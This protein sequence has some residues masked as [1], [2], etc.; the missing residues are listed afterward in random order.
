[1]KKGI[2]RD[3]T[4]TSWKHTLLL[5]LSVI[6]MTI[7]IIWRAFFTLPFGYGTVALVVGILLL[8][9]EALAAIE[10]F[11]EYYQINR[12]VIP[13]FPEID[14]SMYPDVDI[15]IATHNE[16]VELLYKTVNACTFLD[17][18]DRSKVHIYLCDDNNRPEMAELA[19]SLSV[20]YFGLEENKHAKAGNLNNA[21]KQTHSPLVAT[22]DSDMIVRSSFLM[23]TV[24]YFFLP[25]MKKND[26]G[27]WV[28]REE[29]EIDETYKIGF[30]QTPQSFYN[31]D[32]FQYNLYSE[33]RIP[34][35][36]DY[37][38]RDVNVGRNTSNAPIY[39]GSNTLLSREALEAAGYIAVNSIT[40]DF[41]TGMRIQKKG[42]CCFAIP[43]SVANG[44]APDSVK[45]LL[46]QRERW[47]RG[48]VQSCRNE[49]VI[50]TP[51]LTIAQK[52]SYLATKLYWWTFSRRAVYIL[53]PVLSVLFNLRIVIAPLWQVL[54]FWLPS[55]LL[56]N[57]TLR[58]L[59]GNIRNQHL[60]NIFDTIMFP[61]LIFPIVLETL[62]IKQRKFIVTDKKRNKSS[63]RTPLLFGL[64]H[65][66]LLAACICSFVIC[67]NISLA[68]GTLYNVIILYWL[69]INSKNLVFALFFMYG[70][71][72]FRMAERFYVKN[73]VEL[74]LED[75]NLDGWTFDISETGM[76]IALP[77]PEYIPP[78]QSVLLKIR[79]HIYEAEMKVEI[80]NVSAS[81]SSWKYSLRIADI[82]DD[83]RRQYMQIV[84]DREHSLPKELDKNLSV[85]DDFNINLMQRVKRY[86]PSLRKL[87]RIH[88]ELV[89]KTEDG[90]D[91]VIEDFNYR[92]A[93]IKTSAAISLQDILVVKYSPDT[94]FEFA[95]LENAPHHYNV[96]LYEVVNAEKFIYNRAFDVVLDEWIKRNKEESPDPV[97]GDAEVVPVSKMYHKKRKESL[98]AGGETT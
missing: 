36:Q 56:Y 55:Y 16:S 50:V 59:S 15:L 48:C 76:A 2:I 11:I 12:H 54:L 31:P 22:F 10:A 69:V 53:A 43:V 81:G 98:S 65:L 83:N 84:Y 25:V 32:L 62:F 90:H 26:E 61:Y 24:P 29:D 97:I 71:T 74:Q 34:N 78:D 72:N 35:E 46:K 57:R 58:V 9:A 1:V 49:H 40:E 8:G 60:S 73:D 47:G 93:S 70:R 80:A 91:G 96:Q 28:K 92:F 30:I 77:R 86:R 42:Y 79:Y 66:I 4:K 38:F 44:L 37:F 23:E 88:L 51:Y 89:F 82:D 13:E 20:G 33:T 67:V 18:P 75:R 94:L 85:F 39:A 68:S 6:T 7:Y 64:P 87:P 63:S 21:L 14:T 41:S 27:L 45:S 17:Y 95:L 3:K 52:I 19:R 5:V